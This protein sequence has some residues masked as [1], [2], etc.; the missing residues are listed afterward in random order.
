MNQ[1]KLAL[2]CLHAVLAYQ[3]VPI[4]RRQLI[5]YFISLHLRQDKFIHVSFLRMH[6]EAYGQQPRY[7]RVQGSFL[8]PSL[9]YQNRCF[10]SPSQCNLLVLYWCIYATTVIYTYISVARPASNIPSHAGS[11]ERGSAHPVSC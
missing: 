6:Q 5:C 8:L 2:L 4:H 3:F 11:V 9:N 10:S 7:V 1:H